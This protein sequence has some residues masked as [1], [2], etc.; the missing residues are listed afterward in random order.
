MTRNNIYIASMYRVGIIYPIASNVNLYLHS[1]VCTLYND[2]TGVWS[3]K[4]I[5]KYNHH[6]CM[7]NTWVY[8]SIYNISSHFSDHCTTY[9]SIYMGNQWTRRN[10]IQVTKRYP[11]PKLSLP[12][13][14]ESFLCSK[15]KMLCIQKLIQSYISLSQNCT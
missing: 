1:V 5:E 12:V 10:V 9:I 6:E 4:H 13:R 14:S 11:A 3:M 7:K 2:H 8:M 15:K